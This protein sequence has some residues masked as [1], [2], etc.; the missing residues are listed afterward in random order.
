MSGMRRLCLNEVLDI[1]LPHAC[2]MGA[3]LAIARDLRRTDRL[4][5]PTSRTQSCAGQVCMFTIMPGMVP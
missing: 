2:D 1:A 3:V 4:H 5:V